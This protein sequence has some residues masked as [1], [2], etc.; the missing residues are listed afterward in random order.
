MCQG[1]VAS[2]SFT[3]VVSLNKRQIVDCDRAN[4]YGRPELFDC[5]FSARTAKFSR[6]RRRESF[7]CSISFD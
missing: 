5:N 6:Q 4:N 1:G 7:V 3:F 2:T